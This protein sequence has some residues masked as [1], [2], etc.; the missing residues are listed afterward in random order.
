MHQN[1]LFLLLLA[2]VETQSLFASHGKS[3]RLNTRS[4]SILSN[5][6]SSRTQL[7]LSK[8]PLRWLLQSMII[9]SIVF[10]TSHLNAHAQ[11]PM[12][13]EFNQGSGSKIVKTEKPGVVGGKMIVG[14]TMQDTVKESAKACG[15]LRQI[16]QKQDWESVLNLRNRLKV[17]RSKNFGV[18]GGSGGLSKELGI[19]ADAAQKIESIRD[20]LSYA[21]SSLSEYALTHRVIV[22]NSEDLKGIKETGDG[23]GSLTTEED[24]KEMEGLADT[25]LKDFKDIMQFLG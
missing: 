7:H 25:I 16:V 21:L 9:S 10:D 8:L 11:I 23:T 6:I 17:V 13:E 19:S 15:S 18:S 24:I 22:F 3:D 20:D 4:K 14:E 12:M 2:V 1:I 5:S